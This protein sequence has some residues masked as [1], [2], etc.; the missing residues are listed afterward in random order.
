MEFRFVRCSI[1]VDG[2]EVETFRWMNEELRQVRLLFV[3]NE[4]LRC[5]NSPPLL[6]QQEL[7]EATV[8][9][10]KKTQGQTKKLPNEPSLIETLHLRLAFLMKDSIFKKHILIQ[11]TKTKTGIRGIYANPFVE[12]PIYFYMVVRNRPGFN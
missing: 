9:I 12:L 4:L 5:L 3:E 2:R 10:L 1:E 8:T 7:L 11:Q 6:I